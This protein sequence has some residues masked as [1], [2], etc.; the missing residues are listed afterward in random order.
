LVIVYDLIFVVFCILYSPFLFLKR[1]W[2]KGFGMRFGFL[3]AELKRA[4]AQKPHI[5]VHAVS[6]G[7]VMA[8][9]NLVKKLKQRVPHIGIVVSTVT[10]TGYALARTQMDEQDLVIYAP[11]DFSAAVHRFIHHIRPVLYII[12][13]TEIWPNIFC[14]LAKKGVP[15]V[16]VNGR[17]SDKGFRRYFAVR[18]LLRPVLKCVRM[19]CMQ[20]P[21]DRERILALGV[22]EEK[23]HAVGN[24]KLDQADDP[25]RF[26]FGNVFRAWKGPVWVAGS[27]HPGEEDIIIKVYKTLRI[28]FSN[29][30]LVLAPRHIERADAVG[31]LFKQHGLSAQRLSKLLEGEALHSDIVL[32]DTIGHLKHLY[33]VADFVFIGKSLCG[34]GGQNM[35]EPAALGKPVV[36][37]PNTQN[38]KGIMDILLQNKAILQVRSKIEL[39]NTMDKLLRDPAFARKIGQSA[40]SAIQ[41]HQGATERTLEKMAPILKNL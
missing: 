31:S 27:T 38:F 2:H 12:A 20:S 34:Y 35:I 18:F 14:A 15:I 16:Q 17:I 11:L 24:M 5:W 9:M 39:R 37:G 40:Q 33:C 10:P 19:F 28:S 7:E 4:L 6:V 41:A 26:G 29:L 8:V 3:P 32:V 36:V 1:K 22:A 25:E 23:V 21:L 30:R 13:E